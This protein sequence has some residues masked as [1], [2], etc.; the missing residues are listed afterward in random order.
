MKRSFYVA[1]ILL[2]LI[3]PTLV[4]ADDINDYNNILYST[5]SGKITD[6]EGNPLEGVHVK[7]LVTAINTARSFETYS[8][9]FGMY[10]FDDLPY[11][12]RSPRLQYAITFFL[13]GY[14]LSTG[15]RF[16]F[17]QNNY[18]VQLKK[19]HYLINDRYIEADLPV[20]FI[21]VG[22]SGG[23][24]V[25]EAVCEII[26]LKCDY[27]SGSVPSQKILNSGVG[28]LEYNP[29]TDSPL[30][31]IKN[32]DFPDGTQY[33]TIVLAMGSAAVGMSY[34]YYLFD[35]PAAKEVIEWAE[36][37]HVTI[38]GMCVSPSLPKTVENE[39]IINALA[40][41]C[42][43]LIVLNTSNYEDMYAKIALENNIPLWCI[44]TNK[45]IIDIFQ[46]V[47]QNKQ[48]VVKAF[49]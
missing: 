19:F 29:K 18:D 27:I 48:L 2:V 35:I 9:S 1:L 49:N 45:A 4:S 7:V 47:F 21:D 43:M 42:D 40:H 15:E 36:Q 31:Y 34:P 12:D 14:F 8:D 13:D 23:T 28:L 25:A 30:L 6:S 5:I 10:F 24:Y 44:S 46:K 32:S 20:L 37:N 22:Q 38:L 41:K 33:N 16:L 39:A 17:T 26:N 11:S 3:L